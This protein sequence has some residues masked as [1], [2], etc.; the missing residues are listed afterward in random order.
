MSRSIDD[1]SVDSLEG[2]MA[3]LEALGRI[4]RTS[5][6]LLRRG[7]ELRQARLRGVIPIPHYD[8]SP[9]NFSTIFSICL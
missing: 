2:L 3:T 8:R 5:Q 7:A 4:F 1:K 6:R 9:R